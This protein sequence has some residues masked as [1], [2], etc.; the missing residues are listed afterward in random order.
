[1]KNDYYRTLAII[2]WILLIFSVIQVFLFPIFI[3][4]LP[5]FFI[6]T[7]V[8]FLLAAFVKK[9]ETAF[10]SYLNNDKE[11]FIYNLKLVS[12]LLYIVS[13][14]PLICG[15]IRYIEYASNDPSFWSTLANV[16]GLMLTLVSV[17]CLFVS[18]YLIK[19]FNY[20]IKNVRAYTIGYGAY[21]GNDYNNADNYNA[22]DDSDKEQKE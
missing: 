6:P 20:G 11:S 22:D 16:I 10:P 15:F 5:I 18:G 9:M 12:R 3:F 1:M 13:V 8:F 17:I 14:I 4:P 21:D 7:A 2:G 19:V